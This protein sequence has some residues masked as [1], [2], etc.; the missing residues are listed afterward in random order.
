[1]SPRSLVPIGG[2]GLASG[3][4]TAVKAL[5][6][7]ARVIGVEPE[8]AADAQASLA[9]RRDRPL[10]GRA[11]VSRTIADGTRTQALGRRGRSPTCARSSTRS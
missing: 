5:D 3:V 2:G 10:A 9:A 7:S 6:P 1:M 4:A 8:L 11:V